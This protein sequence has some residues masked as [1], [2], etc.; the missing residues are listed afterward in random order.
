MLQISKQRGQ[1]NER[2]SPLDEMVTTE[3]T[4]EGMMLQSRRTFLKTTTA[5]SA[6]LALG[7]PLRLFA[8]PSQKLKIGGF[9]KELQSLSYEKTAE[10]VSK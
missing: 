2:E 9:T 3:S 4:S 5:A 10:V 1:S 7:S 8:K 6:A